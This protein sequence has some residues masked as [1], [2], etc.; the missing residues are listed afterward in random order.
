[1]TNSLFFGGV[2]LISTKAN[3]VVGHLKTGSIEFLGQV[4]I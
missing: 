1:M 4:I 3:Y 2:N